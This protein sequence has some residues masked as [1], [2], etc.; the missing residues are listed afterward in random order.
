MKNAKTYWRIFIKPNALTNYERYPDT[1]DSEH[2]AL[3]S[4]VHARLFISIDTISCTTTTRRM[5]PCYTWSAPA[6]WQLIWPITSSNGINW[7]FPHP[8][9]KVSNCLP[10]ATQSALTWRNGSSRWWAFAILGTS[11]VTHYQFS[12]GV[13]ILIQKM[14]STSD[15][16]SA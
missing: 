9:R 1:K 3:Y 6:N 4:A 10:A 13:N 12:T 15:L 2:P 11:G 14:G 8:A 5:P 16:R 7:A